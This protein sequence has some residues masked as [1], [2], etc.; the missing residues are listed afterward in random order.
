[1]AG[2]LDASLPVGNEGAG[3]VVKA[4]ASDAARALVG[5]TVAMIGGAMYAQYRCIKVADCLVLPDGATP[6]DGASSFVNPLTALGMV[7]TMRREGHSALAHTAAA[8]NLG[9]MLNKICIKD[10]IGLVNI[11]RTAEQEGILRNIGAA[12]VCNSTTPT[13]MEDLT[14][15][16]VTTGATLAFDAIGGGKLAS[17]ILSCMEAAAARNAKTYSR[18][19]S[20]V[21][22]QVYI[23]GGLDVRPTELSRGFGM[24]WR[25]AAVPVLAENRTRR[26]AKAAST[27]RR[28]TQDDVRQQLHEGRVTTRGASASND[29]RVQQARHGREIPH[30]PEQGRGLATA[31]TLQVD[32]SRLGPGVMHVIAHHR[33]KPTRRHTICL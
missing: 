33:G 14:R 7:E 15:A 25:L 13:F 4:G 23:Y 27:G 16:L 5:K 24:A 11:V 1:M 19:G 26:R 18:Y 9:Q 32:P 22:K 3:V 31:G 10:G 28:R 2:R 29:R 8:S 12:Y 21:H 6:A 30:Q 17:Q 20:T